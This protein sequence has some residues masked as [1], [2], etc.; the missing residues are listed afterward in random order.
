MN[1]QYEL[2]KHFGYDSFR[3]SQET[4]I[5]SLLQKEDVLAIMATGSGKSVCYQLPAYL[6][7]GLTVVV[8]PLLSLME[9]QMQ[10]MQQKRMKKV[11]M[12]NSFLSFSEKENVLRN[13]SALKLLFIS[14]ESL[15]LDKVKR[16]LGS[17]TVSLL[18][19]DE[20]HCI[21]Q[22]GHEF[23]TDYLKIKE[24]RKEIGSPTV[25]AVTATA[26]P[27]VQE[28]IVNQLEMKNPLIVKESTNRPSISIH[29]K[30]TNSDE[31]KNNELL[32]T[33]NHS[34]DP[35]M[36][37]FSSRAAA[38]QMSAFLEINTNKRV[39]AY[40][41]GM[42]QEDRILVQQQFLQD[43][44]DVVCCT[45]AFGMGI[46]KPDVRYVI[47][48]HYPKDLESYVQ[49]IGRAGRDGKRSSALLL[50]K[51][52]DIYLPRFFIEMEF[53]AEEEIDWLVSHITEVPE[54][55][56]NRLEESALNRG[57]EE[58]HI[59]F[60]LHYYR[61]WKKNP[62]GQLADKIK[63]VK[64][65]RTIW[66][67]QKLHSMEEWL[68]ETAC[69]RE[70]LLHYFGETLQEKP[71]HCCD[72]CQAHWVAPDTVQKREKRKVFELSWKQRL[73][74]LLLTTESGSAKGE[75]G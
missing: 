39:S 16:A 31:E 33:I 1:L 5:R 24:I 41:G 60:F 29:V 19:V 70:A 40:H 14:P 69:R 67:Q 17:V 52:D 54:I 72:L 13:L 61:E 20:A 59:R 71:E 47:H 37:Y 49:E 2:K 15:Q 6:Q 12:Y 68:L 34:P 55:S 21:S 32:R 36:V 7:P 51:E 58:N 28:D 38:E 56:E 62:G 11:D 74:D 73:E 75:K 4:I 30:K 35:G 8:S 46:N 65:R 9:N 50:Y 10:E 44:L 66:K 64:Q 26:A 23:R 42:L 18:A 43:E 27:S 57:W 45:N 22:W 3:N 53:P 25:L 48:Y 63:E